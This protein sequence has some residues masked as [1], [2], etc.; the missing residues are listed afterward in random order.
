MLSYRLFVGHRGRRVYLA[1][2]LCL[3]ALSI[4]VRVRSYLLTRKIYAVLSGLDRLR[5]DATTEEQLL[6]TVPYLVR[7]KNTLPGTQ[8]YYRAEISNEGDRRWL[9]RLPSFLYSLWPLRVDLP[10]KAM[11]NKWELMPV[12]TKIAYVLGWR[13]VSFSAY[14]FVLNGT[15]WSTGYSI[16]PDVLVGYPLSYFVVARSAHGFW[17]N[18]SREQPV[19]STDD[20]SPDYRFG[21]VAGQ[22]SLLA[23]ADSSIGVVY[24]ATA[25]RDLVSHVYQVDLSCF[26]AI[27]GCDSVRQVTPL[28]WQDRQAIATAT[29]SRVSS[30]AG[31]SS[32]GNPC[33]D[34]IL[35][36]RVRTLLDV[37]VALLE[38]LNSRS[39]LVNREGT[40]SEE[41][42]TDYRLIEALRGQPQGPWTDIRYRWAIPW[43][44][45]PTGEVLNP[46]RPSYPKPGER[47]LYFSGASFD[48]CRIVPATPSAESSVRSA[49]PAPRR[50]ED[51]VTRYLYAR[52]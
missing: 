37:N 52:K 12:P 13:Q 23:G 24:T 4:G 18:R 39:E 47:V 46:M 10:R 33:P 11:T 38:V 49:L 48:S 14:V 3:F 51:D 6:K 32:S 19:Q 9:Y 34:R 2:F 42:V 29:T 50:S 7:E 40:V 17:T 30:M 8:G 41:I 31:W 1:L 43:P 20:E 26:W 27:R 22:F 21:A 16:E 35:A 44:S 45:S 5:V 28:L 15:V 36:G 25:P